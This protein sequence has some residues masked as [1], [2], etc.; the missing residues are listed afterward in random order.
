MEAI[1]QYM[2]RQTAALSADVL[3]GTTNSRFT[4]STSAINHFCVV[5]LSAFYFDVL[6]DR[7]YTLPRIRRA[8]AP[9][10]PRS[11]GSAKR[12]VR[13]LAPIM[14]FTCEEVWQ[15]LPKIESRP[16]SVHLDKFPAAADILGRAD[17]PT[18]DPEQQSEWTTLR[19][20]RDQVLKQLEEARTRNEIG[21][22]VEAQVILTAS[23]PLYTVLEKY[24]NDLRYLFIVS[25]V[26]LERAAAGNG[27]GAL[28]VEVRKA[29]GAKCERCWNYSTHVGEDKEYPTVCERCAPVLK[30]LGETAAAK[31]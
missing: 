15:Y 2:L 13:L 19:E 21:K 3:A 7:L 16:E 31:S 27:T 24:K 17:I 1:D 8:G 9:R 12:L 10:R 4:R 22:S 5:E 18:E 14:S 30:E 26:E 29:D 23:D 20:I 6:K 25:Q 11:G 28:I